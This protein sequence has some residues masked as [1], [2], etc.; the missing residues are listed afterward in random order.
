MSEF[1]VRDGS[2]LFRL[3]MAARRVHAAGKR[4]RAIQD[5]AWVEAYSD[6]DRALSDADANIARGLASILNDAEGEEGR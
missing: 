6:L 5:P 2:V 1:V 3:I 4:Y